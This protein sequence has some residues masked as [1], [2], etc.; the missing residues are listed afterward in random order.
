[1]KTTF[2]LK[3]F[4]SPN[5]RFDMMEKVRETAKYCGYTMYAFNG[6]VRSV[7]DNEILF[8]LKDIVPND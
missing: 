4:A 7:S 1:M 3:I 8:N 5:C 2:L 6:I